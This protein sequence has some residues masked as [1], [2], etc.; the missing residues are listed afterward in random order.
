MEMSIACK[1][2]VGSMLEETHTTWYVNIPAIAV[3][4]VMATVE[5]MTM[6]FGRSKP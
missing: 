5:M 2:A 1:G 6:R 3:N 4:S